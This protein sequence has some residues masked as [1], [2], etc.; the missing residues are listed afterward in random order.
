MNRQITF[1][2]RLEFRADI[3]KEIFGLELFSYY[4]SLFLNFLGKLELKILVHGKVSNDSGNSKKSSTRKV[5]IQSHLKLI[6]KVEKLIIKFQVKWQ[7]SHSTKQNPIYLIFHLSLNRIYLIIQMWFSQMQIRRIVQ[8]ENR[9][10]KTSIS[11][12]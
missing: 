5:S 7:V 4:H 8:I 3:A 10:W 11:F 2:F 6:N 12:V 9:L 1:R